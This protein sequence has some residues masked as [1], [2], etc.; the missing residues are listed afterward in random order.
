VVAEI[1]NHFGDKVFSAIIP[2]NVRLSEA[3]SHGQTIFQYDPKSLGAK[4]YRELA[5][6]LDQR[7]YGSP[8]VAK[9]EAAPEVVTA[10]TPVPP[11]EEIRAHETASSPD[12][13][14]LGEMSDEEL[15]LL[16]APPRDGDVHV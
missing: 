8:A 6:E 1:Q 15:E 9:P 16:T 11:Q 3:P 2:R 4:K 7:V 12:I 10:E 5:E 13:Q 14:D